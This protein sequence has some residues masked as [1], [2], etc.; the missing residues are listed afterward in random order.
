MLVKGIKIFLRNKEKR[1]YGR[2]CYKNPSEDEKQNIVDYRENY[3]KKQKGC[4]IRF[5]FLYIRVKMG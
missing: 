4:L 3:N 5:R 2:E 1:E